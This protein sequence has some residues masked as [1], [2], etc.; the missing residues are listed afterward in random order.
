MSGGV[1]QYDR[2]YYPDNIVIYIDNIDT[3]MYLYMS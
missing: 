2:N 1:G 3:L